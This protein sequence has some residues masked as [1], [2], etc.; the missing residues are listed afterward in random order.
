MG[1][2]TFNDAR[3][4]TSCCA[5]VLGLDCSPQGVELSDGH[6]ACVGTFPVGIEPQRI[7]QKLEEQ[8]VQDKLAEFQ[9]NFKGVKVVLG[10]NRHDHMSGISKKFLA[11]E[12]RPTFVACGLVVQA[13]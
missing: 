4:F 10:H 7:I 2:Q 6:F 12:V 3:H 1:F 5:M 11:F 9:R 13:L 8:E